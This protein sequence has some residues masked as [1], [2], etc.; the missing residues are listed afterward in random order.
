MPEHWLHDG[1]G[2]GFGSHNLTVIH[3]PGHSP[4]SVVYYCESDH[5][6]FTGDTLFYN[7]IGRTDLFG[8][9]P[10]VYKKSLR[11]LLELPDETIIQSGHTKKT[12]IER[13]RQQNPYLQDLFFNP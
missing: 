4:G 10:E 3:T 2:V 1:D 12:T 13:E 11:K 5:I 8:S 6:A 9:D 7:S